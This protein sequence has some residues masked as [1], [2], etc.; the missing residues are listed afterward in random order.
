MA[1]SRMVSVLH[2]E[3][4]MPVRHTSEDLEQTVA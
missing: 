2:D 3:F 4:E 1:A